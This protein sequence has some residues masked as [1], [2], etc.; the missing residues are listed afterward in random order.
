MHPGAGRAGYDLVA[1]RLSNRRFVRQPNLKVQPGPGAPK[2]ELGHFLILTRPS[3]SALTCLKTHPCDRD[4][5]QGPG[6]GALVAS[7]LVTRELE[8]RSLLAVESEP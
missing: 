5:D 4:I 2:I 7:R 1:I 8:R 6:P 3:R